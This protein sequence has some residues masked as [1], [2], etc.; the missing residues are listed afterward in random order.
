M[1]RWKGDE[2]EIALFGVNYYTPFTADYEGLD[3]LGEDHRKAIDRDVAHF[4]RLGL[5]V[6]RLHVFDRQISDKQGN[7]IENDHLDLFDYLV[8]VCKRRSISTVL[9]PIAW[10]QYHH[11]DAGFSSLYSKPQM[12]TDPEARLA[13]QRSRNNFPISLTPHAAVSPVWSCSP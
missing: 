2:S 13:Q 4:A 3:L 12:L 1:L 10:W 5:D 6:I 11:P 8:G 7:L 9:T